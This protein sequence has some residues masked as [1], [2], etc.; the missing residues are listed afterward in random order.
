VKFDSL[1]YGSF[2]RRDNRFLVQVKIAGCVNAA[3]LANSGRLRELLVPG[4][5][6]WLVPADLERNPRRRTSYDLALVEF[7][8]RLVSVD[9]RVPGQLVSAALC[10]HQLT[11]FEG[12]ETVQR[13]VRLGQSR[14]DFRLVSDSEKPHCWI[15]VKSVTLIDPRTHAARFPDAPTLRGQR[16]VNELIRAVGTGER[17]A[18]V[19]VIRRDD[20]ERFEPHHEA[21]PAFGQTLRLAVQAGVEVYA[22]RCHVSQQAIRLVDTVPVVL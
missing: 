22:W 4:C 16:H 6:V 19:F 20:A 21:D 15:E 9:A 10:H 17:A 3:H 7:A 18:V 12:Y 8:G 14:I 5:K 2:V 13:E 11:G 1:V